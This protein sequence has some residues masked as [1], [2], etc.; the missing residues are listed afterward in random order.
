MKDSS[1]LKVYFSFTTNNS[2]YRIYMYIQ[3]YMCQFFCI[4]L[5]GNNDPFAIE[6]SGRLGRTSSTE[7]YAFFYR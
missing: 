7:Q 4:F 2:V 6:M 1:N 5:S 3:L